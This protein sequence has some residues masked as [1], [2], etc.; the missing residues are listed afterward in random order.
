MPKDDALRQLL[1]GFAASSNGRLAFRVTTST[2]LAEES[3]LRLAR[4][5]NPVYV[6]TLTDSNGEQ[7]T[8]V[9]FTLTLDGDRRPATRAEALGRGGLKR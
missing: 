8:C 1:G 5:T 7:Q 9:A 6:F 3:G 4:S 2:Q